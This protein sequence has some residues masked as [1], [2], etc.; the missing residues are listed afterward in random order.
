[1]RNLARRLSTSVLAM[2]VAVAAFGSPAYAANPYT[3]AS[4]CNDEFGGSWTQV[5]DGHRSIIA[6]DGADL[7]DVYLMYNSTTGY[8]CV[9]ML[10]TKYAGTGS[11]IKASI[12]VDE[13]GTAR[14]WHSDNG[15]Y[16]YYAAVQRYGKGMCI[17]YWASTL[18]GGFWQGN[19]RDSWGNCI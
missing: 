15:F 1:M 19:G 12:K 9:T 7:G 4:A 6:D 13:E 14:D 8:N 2:A 17:Q 3:P 16:K 18:Y 10:K 11:S 5:S